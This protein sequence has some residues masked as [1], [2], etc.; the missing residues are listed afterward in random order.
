M[1]HPKGAF[2][3][4]KVSAAAHRKQVKRAFLIKSVID[5]KIFI[6]DKNSCFLGLGV[7]NIRKRCE[8]MINYVD[9]YVYTFTDTPTANQIALLN[10]QHC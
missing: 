2:C 9:K 10:H 5:T 1:R 6:T 4:H 8:N 3:G 7:A